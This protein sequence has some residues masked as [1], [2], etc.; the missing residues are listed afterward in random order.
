MN[1]NPALVVFGLYMIAVGMI[2]HAMEFGGHAFD[3]MLGDF[4][5]S[6][7]PVLKIPIPE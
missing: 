4:K 5:L 7:D 1:L 3:D 2:Y 6:V